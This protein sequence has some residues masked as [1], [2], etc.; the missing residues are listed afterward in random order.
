MI[1]GS[2][3]VSFA[4]YKITGM[5]ADTVGLMNLGYSSVSIM[6]AQDSLLQDYTRANEDGIFELEVNKPGDYFIR[7]AH[8]SFTTLVE[9]IHIKD[10]VTNLDTVHLI[11]LQNL[12]EEVIVRASRP[13]TIKGDTI[14]YTADSFQVSAYATVDELLRKLP[15][16]EIDKNGK[17]KAQGQDVKR[18][19]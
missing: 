15:G 17:I 2:I 5:L 13:I 3:K 1:C 9:D 4:Q 6:S 18:W 16:I 8:P 12:L 10:A 11:T 19:R 14:E 7:Y